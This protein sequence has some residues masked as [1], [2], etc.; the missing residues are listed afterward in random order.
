MTLPIKQPAPA[1][2]AARPASPPPAGSPR[3]MPDFANN[4]VLGV[5]IALVI[6]FAIFTA[7]V[8]SFLSVAN[9]LEMGVQSAI[10][11][12]IALGMT[13]VIV[14]GGID[15]SVGSIVG[16]VSVICAANLE[17]WGAVPTIIAGIL[18]G[19]VLGFVN[20]SL[21]AVFSLES[22]VVTLATLNVYRGLA[23]LYTDGLPIFGLDQGFRNILSGTVGTIPNP[24]VLLV[25]VTVICYLILN[26]SKLGV[27]LKAVGTNADA[28]LKSGIAVKR[29]KVSAFVIAGGLAGLASVLLISRIGA[30]EPISGT[31]YELT[32]IAA[33]VV[34]GT[35]LMGGR[36]SIVG[37]VLGALLLG[38]IR[39]GL[40]L[41]N[42]NPFFQLVITGLIIL[43]AVLVDRAA[44]R[45]KAKR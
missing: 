14:T 25:A 45:T 10:I 2:Q 27:H 30:A 1:A 22:F 29:V 23:F 32:V 11:A 21:S 12:I 31:G 38:S 44:S 9:L 7:L 20:G 17:T 36:A 5:I 42:V 13:L 43:L 26:R 16:L 8:P 33:V 6:T 18:L 24:I 34:G 19:A 39:T 35:S 40:T 41:L 15:L 4:R 3:R 28:S 37:T